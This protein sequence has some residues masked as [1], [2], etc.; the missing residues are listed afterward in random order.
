MHKVVILSSHRPSVGWLAKNMAGAS[1][2]NAHQRSDPRKKRQFRVAQQPTG[3]KPNDTAAHRALTY[4]WRRRVLSK[5][6]FLLAL[7]TNEDRAVK[8]VSPGTTPGPS[9]SVSID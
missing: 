1:G 3:T 7:R 5:A 2:P 6:P 9:L 4:F 8:P